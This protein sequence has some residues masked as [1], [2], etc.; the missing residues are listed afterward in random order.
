MKFDGTGD[1]LTMPLSA[2]T[3]IT[4]GNFTVEFWL[5]PSTVATA[6]QAIIGT[7]EGDTAGTI[8]WMAY[9]VS[10]S[11]YFQC[12]SNSS[13]LMVQ[14]NHQ[15]S[16]S[17]GNWYYCAVTRSG[18]TFTLYLNGVASTSTPTSSATINQSG[19]TLYVGKF[20][21]SSSIGAL[22]GYIQDLRITKGVARTITTPTAAFP[23]R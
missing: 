3:T 1:Y 15:T 10:S 13:T 19:S 16:L 11:L 9:L 7:T 6:T 21:A 17:A 18:S 4:S 14:F 2:G 23:T 5:Y 12:Y 20:G 8:N 22:N